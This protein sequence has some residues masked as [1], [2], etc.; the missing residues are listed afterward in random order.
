MMQFYLNGYKTGDPLIEDPDPAVAERPGGLPEEADVLIIGCG[1]AGLVL[2]AQMANFPGIQT[3]VIDR[4][5]GP[6]E[7]GQADGVACRTVEIFEA[8]GLADRLVAEAYWVNEVSFWRPDPHDRSR[9]TRTGRVQDVEEGLSEFPHV[10]CNQARMLA[11]LQDHMQRSASR[12]RPFYGLH[13]TGV[14]VDTSGQAEYPVTVTIQHVEGFQETGET[15]TIRAKYVVGCDGARSG[16]RTAIGRRLAGDPMN[17]SWGVMDVLAVTD[18]PDIRLKC[19]IHSANQGNL[20]II[21]REGGYLARFYIEL[22]QE[23]DREM[24]RNR[25]VNP[26]KLVAVANRILHPYT[27][28]VKDVGWWSVYEIGQRL[29]DKFDDV[30]VSELATRLPRVFIAGDA[31]H[32][33]SAKAGQGMNVSMSDAW[34][35]GWKLAQVLRGTAKPELLHTY[36]SERQKVAQELIDFDR[37][38]ARMF[39]APP[40]ETSDI[41]GVG[42][43]P[44][45]FQR[46]FV[47]QGRFTAGVATRYA[48]SM[49]TAEAPYQ[50]LAKG[51]PVGMR[52]HSAPVLRLADAK[53]MHLGHVAR[54]DGAWRLY[55]FADR[56]DPASRSSEARKLCEFLASENSP[57]ARFT[58]EG[59]GPDS[60]IDIRAVFQQD[61]RDLAVNSMPAIL[62]PAKGKFSL[63]D[64]EKAFCADPRA[65]DIFDLRSID[66]VTGCLVVVRPDQYVSHVLPLD[67]TGE[68]VGFFAGIL[69]DAR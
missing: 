16:V 40:K 26:E 11:Y 51:F 24:L 62:L 12:L 22:D 30:P 47:Q 10:I 66:R 13:A 59:T 44:E 50:H 29:C 68:L 49:I 42:V 64:Y 1:P 63:I 57:I 25:S 65:G 37:E 15:S 21:P 48:P 56:A 46:H 36:S 23:H 54:A 69:I 38:F 17:Q 61:H 19:V 31:C 58:P 41:E 28:E 33:H 55:V 7:V 27:L 34:N 8:F 14:R 4:R 6:L 60:V 67:A 43:V 35:L 20:L 3:V 2:A 45:E 53:P 52:F 18:F 39:S 32:T 5:D 9:I